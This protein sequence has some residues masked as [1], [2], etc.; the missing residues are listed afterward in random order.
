M[1]RIVKYVFMSVIIQNQTLNSYYL[2][3]SDF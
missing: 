3:Q 1:Q 2:Y